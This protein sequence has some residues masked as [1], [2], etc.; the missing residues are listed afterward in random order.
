[1][2]YEAEYQRK[3]IDAD[4]AAALV[5]SGD[6]VDYGFG[7]GQPDLPQRFIYGREIGLM[8][9]SHGEVL[10]NGNP[11]MA[12]GESLAEVCNGFQRGALYIS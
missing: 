10:L 6:W 9:P 4:G 2:A 5:K 11:E 1:M 3:V 12:I 7:V 8:Y